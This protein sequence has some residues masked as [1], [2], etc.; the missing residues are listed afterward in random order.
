[1]LT[2]QTSMAYMTKKKKKAD[3]QTSPKSHIYFTV[4]SK[5]PSR[6]KMVFVILQGRLIKVY[7]PR[8]TH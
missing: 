4:S 2:F 7:L 8:R 5:M 3:E 6:V 1:M